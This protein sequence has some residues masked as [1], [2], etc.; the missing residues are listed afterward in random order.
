MPTHDDSKEQPSTYIV[1]DRASRDEMARLQAQ[2]R[3]FNTSL[4]GVLSEQPD[5]TRFTHV[6]DVGCGP[7]GWLIETAKTYPGMARLVGIDISQKMLDTARTQAS[8]EHLDE[9]VEFHMMDA[10]H[11]LA[12]PASSF[13]LINQ[14]AGISWLRTWDWPALL[15]EY[16]RVAR[17][18]GVIRITENS[19]FEC[20]SPALTRLWDL[21]AQAFYQAGTS[22]TPKGDELAAELTRLL[23]RYGLQQVQTRTYDLHYRA[24]TPEGRLF[25]EDMQRLYRTFKPFLQKWIH[26]PGD[27]EEIY[28]QMCHE[29]EQPGFAAIARIFTI[30]GIKP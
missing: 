7:G 17:P 15:Q 27:Y 9:R 4:G 13:D 22:F 19:A 25:A 21:G 1:Q 16:W 10:L 6:L 23:N 24:G 12:F 2:D 26:L 14:R 5:P 29:V 30:W 28:Q 3:L 20:N 11:G 8:A 18:G